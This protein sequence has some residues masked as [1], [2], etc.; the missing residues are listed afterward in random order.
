MTKRATM[1]DIALLA[2]VSQATV[3]LVLSDVANARVSAETRARV[4]AIADELG[5]VPRGAKGRSV[6]ARVVGMIIDE[7]STTPFASPLI[8]GARDAAAAQG[9]VVALFCTGGDPDLEAAA[10]AVLGAMPLAGLLY[11]RLVTQAV[12]VP[13]PVLDAQAILLNCHDP[14]RRLPSVIPGD[15]LGAFGAVQ[16]LTRAG[17]RRIAHISGEDWGEAA[18]DRIK[19]Y[20][21]ALSSA[22]IPFDPALLAGPAWTVAS[23]REHTLRLMDQPDPP[24]AIFCFNDRIAIGCYEALALR[25]LRVPQDVSVIGFDN[26]DLVAHLLPPLTTVVLPHDEMARWAVGLLLG[27]QGQPE[28]S[29]HPEQIKIDCALVSRGSV[30]PPRTGAKSDRV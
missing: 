15:V 22:D 2:G 25:G 27:R 17:H 13:A 4:R 1:V 8:E 30:A 24:T 14:E 20:R 18:Q 10:L 7:V 12:A 16:A 29:R 9:C 11:A 26:E 28:A 23:G 5:Y 21:Q 3:S 6:G 19:G